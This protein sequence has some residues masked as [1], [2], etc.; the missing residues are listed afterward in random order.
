MDELMY[1][2]K[3]RRT[4]RINLIPAQTNAL[5]LLVSFQFTRLWRVPVTNLISG[6]CPTPTSTIF[7]YFSIDRRIFAT[8]SF[9]KTFCPSCFVY[10]QL[11]F[12]ISS[13]RTCASLKGAVAGDWFGLLSSLVFSNHSY[14]LA[15]SLS[16]AMPYALSHSTFS[17]QL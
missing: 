6:L 16:F 15:V 14:S 7:P 2:T 13:R 12:S 9:M 3:C 1:M 11:F 5:C 4:C 17:L 10:I 8:R